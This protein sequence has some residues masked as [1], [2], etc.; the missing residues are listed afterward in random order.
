MKHMVR[1]P[2]PES[3]IMISP[4]GAPWRHPQKPNTAEAFSAE[5]EAKRQEQTRQLMI[6]HA[7]E[8]RQR[9][10]IDDPLFH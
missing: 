10:R 1:K 3:N 8:D 6:R 9:Y 4:N 2:K 5:A 7:N